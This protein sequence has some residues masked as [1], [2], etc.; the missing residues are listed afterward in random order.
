M[1]RKQLS[2]SVLE[3]TDEARK[4]ADWMTNI[5]RNDYAGT[6]YRMDVYEDDEG[7]H[8]IE[9]AE[10]DIIYE[11]DHKSD[12]EAV[13]KLFQERGDAEVVKENDKY[14]IRFKKKK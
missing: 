9:T 4:Y 8:M 5:Q 7:I 12:F 14:I 2:H 10:D 13:L 3:K 6:S 1:K 11:K